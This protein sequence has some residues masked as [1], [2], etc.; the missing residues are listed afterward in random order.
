LSDKIEELKEK[1]QAQSDE[2][3]SRKLEDGREIALQKQ[4]VDF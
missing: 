1:F 3:L 2:F 4:K